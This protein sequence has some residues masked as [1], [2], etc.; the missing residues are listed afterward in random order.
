M[1][2]KAVLHCA[3]FS[4]TCLAMLE[5]IALQVP[6]VWCHGPV[7]LRNFLS[8]LFR[9]ASRNEKRE[10]CACPLAKTAVCCWRDDTLCNSLRKVEL[11]STLRNAS[12][13]KKVCKTTHIILCNPGN[14]S[15]NG[16][17]RQVAE[18]IAQCNRAFSHYKY[19]V[20]DHFDCRAPC[21]S[22]SPATRTG[23]TLCTTKSQDQLLPS[24]FGFTPIHGTAG[25]P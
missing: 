4:A 13:N 22:S 18:K 25:L 19:Y 3:I 7:T 8:S 1:W 23:I 2:V 6:E 17:A 14:L 10:V 20:Q 21:S 5:Y 15:R 9:N 11:S 16:I 24:M 12:C